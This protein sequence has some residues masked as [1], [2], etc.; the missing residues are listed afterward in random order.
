[1]TSATC[2]RWIR[3]KLFWLDGIEPSTC[4]A[5]ERAAGNGLGCHR[6]RR[7]AHRVRVVDIGSLSSE[8][9]RKLRPKLHPNLKDPLRSDEVTAKRKPNYGL[10]EADSD[11]L[12][13]PYG[14]SPARRAAP[15][16]AWC[17]PVSVAE[18][19]SC[20]IQS[21][22]EARDRSG[23][24]VTILTE[25]SHSFHSIYTCTTENE[26]HGI[27]FIRPLWSGLPR[28]EA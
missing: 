5:V 19:T 15:Q 25:F 6:L 17:T 23:R 8:C 1:M 18:R 2:F 11:G 14:R 3:S 22:Q 12:N 26:R 7:C 27:R 28:A 24:S 20:S 4:A 10:R 13:P 9:S 21:G 16:A